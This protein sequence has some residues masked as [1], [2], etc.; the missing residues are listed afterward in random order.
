MQAA[1]ERRYCGVCGY[2]GYFGSD[3]PA[4]TKKGANSSNAMKEGSHQLG[5]GLG[6]EIL[7]LI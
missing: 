3:A 4:V 7:I 6:L 5:V 2:C 1:L